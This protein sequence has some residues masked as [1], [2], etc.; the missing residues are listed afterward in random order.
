MPKGV[1][2]AASAMWVESRALDIT[3]R[4]IAHTLTPGYRKEVM[5]RTSF[6]DELAARGHGREL[7]Q[8][9]GAGVLTN[10]SRFLFNEGARETTGA[11]LDLG[12]AGEGF[13]QVRSPDGKDLLTRAAHFTSDKQGRIVNPDGWP[14]L[15]QGGPIT[16]PPD[17]DR[18][19]VD[20]D[21]RVSYE[22]M[23][24]GLRTETVID[25]LRIVTV[26]SNARLQA[27][28]GQY[29]DPAGQPVRDAT[30]AQV[31][32]GTL[33]KANIEPVQELVDLIAIQR[34]YDAAQKALREQSQAG[35]GFSDILRGG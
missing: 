23:Q 21:G 29:F 6:V 34:R 26:E 27:V 13:Y 5:Q 32:Q 18:I 7:K 11:P 2:A 22:V 24:D 19:L 15:G 14:V 9:G 20:Q 3:A 33:E 12:L 16:V 28:N 1:Y 17:A 30:S 4:N 10:G 31:R 8:D 25:Q 35:S